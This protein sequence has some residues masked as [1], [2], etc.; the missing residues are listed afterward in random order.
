MAGGVGSKHPTNTAVG[1]RPKPCSWAACL[2]ATGMEDGRW[3]D[4]TQFCRRLWSCFGIQ[5]EPTWLYIYI[6][7]TVRS[8]FK[9]IQRHCL[10]NPTNTI[11]I[12]I[13]YV[14][15]PL[16]AEIGRATKRS[17]TVQKLRG[18]AAVDTTFAADEC[19]IG[20]IASTCPNVPTFV[21]LLFTLIEGYHSP[22]G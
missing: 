15:E 14:R 20:L 11:A 19:R 6:S 2:D 7:T 8:D 4:Q 9:D 13:F 21:N 22:L 16:L 12:A 1:R 3:D 10:Q 17:K 18:R 5:R